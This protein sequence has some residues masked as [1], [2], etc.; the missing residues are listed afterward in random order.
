MAES[1]GQS[2]SPVAWGS[3]N[4]PNRISL[5]RLVL[6][7]PFVVLMMNHHRWPEA[8][9]WAMGVFIV[10]ALSDFIDG[11]LARRLNMKTRL[12]AILDPIA[13]KLLII[14]SVVLLSMPDFCVAGAQIE[15][16]VVVAV[17]GKDLLVVLGFVVI[18]LV[19]GRFLVKTALAG[20]M[21]T[22]CQ[23][24]MVV[25]VLIS[26]EING[27]RSALGSNLVRATGWAV[28]AMCL[29][30]VMTYGRVGLAFMLHRQMP[31]D[32]YHPPGGGSKG[33]SE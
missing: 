33:L 5:I 11:Q 2:E 31:L 29:L 8:R 22:F 32:E 16:W 23:L 4:W 19:T 15:S 1:S 20:K 3:L 21:A 13:D 18:Y 9:F 6:V 26:P 27:V 17:V 14:C 10:M 28:V 30:A 25:C 24:I 12:G 7:G